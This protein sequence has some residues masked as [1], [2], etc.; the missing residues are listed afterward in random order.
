MTETRI[1]DPENIDAVAIAAA[2]AILHRGGVVAFP[3]ET[4][5]GLGADATNGDAVRRIFA[6]K[7]RPSYN[8][9]IVHA[10]SPNAARECVTD[11]PESAQILAN[12]FWP[13]PLTLV[14]PRNPRIVDEVTAGLSTVGVRVPAHP[15]ALALLHACGLPIAAPSANRSMQLSPTEGKHVNASLGDSVDM[16]LDAG[17]SQVGIESTV[18]DLSSPIPT[19]LR[20]GMISRSRLEMAIG[21][22]EVATD[23][24]A[25][26][27]ARRSPGMADRHYAPRARLVIAEFDVATEL[28]LA[29]RREGAAGGRIAVLT[30]S[31]Y[32]SEG[33][34]VRHMPADSS[35][36]AR[37]L[38]STLH[39]LDDEGIATIVVGA[40]PSDGSWEAVRDR[41]K[42]AAAR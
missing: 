1:I 36:Y 4:V 37:Q 13:G 18:I 26:G 33:A 9:L 2:A 5:Y 21:R 7:G 14:L 39:A 28:E 25:S 32:E 15:V 24:V 41:L 29:V 38:Y 30:R 42:R 31:D 12:S 17:P 27:V 35:E 11:W 20:P 22:V 34:T 19:I 40:V 3:T 23:K 16:V 10:A 6:A 8:P